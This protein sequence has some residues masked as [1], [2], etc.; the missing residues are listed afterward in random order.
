MVYLLSLLS[1]LQKRFRM[2]AP[3]TMT[4]TALE[5]IPSSSSNNLNKQCTKYRSRILSSLPSYTSLSLVSTCDS[6]CSLMKKTQEERYNCWFTT[7]QQLRSLAPGCSRYITR[8][9]QFKVTP[10]TTKEA[11]RTTGEVNQ[12][13]GLTSALAS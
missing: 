10:R 8:C 7:L 3:D 11:D 2:S 9:M 1:W 13:T 6:S 5:A 4:N 12:N